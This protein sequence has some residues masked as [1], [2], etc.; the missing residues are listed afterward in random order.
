MDCKKLRCWLDDAENALHSLRIGAREVEIQHDGKVVRYNPAD[1]ATLRQYVED[2]QRQVAA[3]EGTSFRS[4]R[5][6]IGI[7]PG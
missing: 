1:L 7:I 6:I 5:R 3:C 2:L 4:N